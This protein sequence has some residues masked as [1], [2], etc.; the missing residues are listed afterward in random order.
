MKHFG[1]SKIFKHK[2]WSQFNSN[3]FRVVIQSCL[4]N[5]GYRAENVTF[6]E[7][8]P[9]VN[10]IDQQVLLENHS[11]IPEDNVTIVLTFHPALY[12]IF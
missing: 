4:V 12:I 9:R 10:S 1:A 7:Q 11:K 2:T 8:I 5:R 6:K 3:I